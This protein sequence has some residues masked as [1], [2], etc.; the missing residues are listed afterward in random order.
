VKQ[1]G[2]D[3]WVKDGQGGISGYQFVHVWLKA[4]K[5]AGPD[6]T[7]EKFRAAL[8]TY[9]NYTDLITGPITFKGSPNLSHGATKMAV[10][11]AGVTSYS[12]VT[13]GFVDSF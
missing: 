4:L 2:E 5:D 3:D 1:N 11:K 13:P 9:E 6:P 12:Q 7:R 8:L 10:F